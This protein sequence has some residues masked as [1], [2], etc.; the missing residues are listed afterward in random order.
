MRAVKNILGYGAD[1]RLRKLC[2]ALDAYQEK[3][4]LKR[5]T[6]A[7]LPSHEQHEDQSRPDHGEEESA[8]V[9]T[10]EGR[11]DGSNGNLQAERTAA[12]AD[13]SAAI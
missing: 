13:N 12:Q 7:Q 8:A 11:A 9:Y 1:E 6:E 4:E 5:S 3:V 10:G 2:E